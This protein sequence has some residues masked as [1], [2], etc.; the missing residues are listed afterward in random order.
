MKMK[1]QARARLLLPLLTLAFCLLAGQTRAQSVPVTLR[2]ADAPLEQVLDAIEKQ[3]SYLFVYD[4]SVDVTRKVSLDAANEPLKTVLARLAQQ[5]GVDYAVENTS[6]VLSQKPPVADAQQSVTLTGTV[7]DAQGQPVIGAAVI[8]QGTT[9]GTSTGADGNYTLRI[10]PPASSAV[11]VVN[12]LGYETL[13]IPVGSRTTLDITLRESA[14]DMDAVVVTALGIRRSEKALSY[15]AQQVN[16]DDIVAVKDVNFINSLNGKVAGLNINSSSSGIGGA[17]K[18]VMRGSKSIEQSSNAL[19]V[20]DGIPMCNF[21]SDG[22][23]EFESQGS[24]EAIADLNP[25]DIESMTVLSGAA[26]AALYGSDAA[27][28]AILITTKKGKAGQTTVTVTSNTEVLTPFVMPM[29]QTR[30]GT[31]DMLAGSTTGIYSWGS[32]LNS[33]NYRGYD[34]AD[35]YFQ[36]GVVGTETVALSTGSER[37]QTYVSAG[38]V[39][40]RG[41]I[42]NNGYDRYNFTFRNTTSFLKD[43]LKLDVGA[44]YIIQKD[45]N[46]IN[47]GVYSNPL[48]SAYLFPRGDDWSDIQMYERYNSARGISE[49]YWPSMGTDTYQMQNPYWINY[50]NLRET[51]KDRYMFNASLTYDI[52]DWLSVAGRI[53]VDNSS[54]NYTEK[55]WASTNPLRTEMSPNG[56]YG[57]TKTHDK[58]TYGDVMLNINKSFGDDWTLQANIGA[59]I[60]DMQ[61]DA[62]KVRGPIA[63]GL[64]TGY[65]KDGNPIREPNNIPN[66]F[67]VYNLSRSATVRDQIGWREQV[68]SIFFS[69][70]VGFKGAYYLT[71][72]GRN[73][74]PSQLAGPNSVNSS[75][76][77]PSFGASI[78]VSEI[79]PNM[80]K[81]LSYVK[82][83]TS[84]ASVGLAFSRFYANPTRSWNT[85]TDSWNLSSQSP[86]Y[87]LKPERTKS[88]EVGLTMRFLRHFNLDISYY[89]TRT[90]NQTFNTGIPASS[91]YSKVYKQ[92]GDVRNRGFEASLGYKNTWNRF[93]WETTFTAS[94]NRNKIMKLGQSV[95]DPNTGKERPIGDLNVGGLGNVRF[96]LREGGSLGDIYS[97]ADLRRDSN[98]D[99]YQDP[100]GNIFVDNKS[101]TKDFI[102]L[103]SVFPDANLAWRNDFRWR[104]FNFGFL[105]TARLGGVVYSRTQAVLDYYG[106]SASAADAR[107]AGGVVINGN[108]RIDA[109][110]WYQTVA[111]GDTTPQYYTYSATNVRL[112]EAS[113]GYTIPRKKLGDVCDITVSVVGRNLWMIYNKAPFDPEAVATTGNYYQGVDYFMMPSMRSIGFN[114]R[115]KF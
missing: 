41:I 10:P 5:A 66:V 42:P 61:S 58:Q 31:G 19:Y 94:A 40:S 115:V 89:N 84:Y 97:R 74:W 48:V 21:R 27:N 93:S 65:D 49:Q 1:D 2:V 100:D 96:I 50:R 3:T 114:V 64:E 92:D 113:I 110:K 62:L 55:L 54:S 13:E 38:A 34:P 79:I 59:S 63:Y 76:F 91:M 11:L 72:T 104:N 75:F 23:E 29:F 95:I 103:G 107:D 6:I 7:R 16:A 14:V 12:Y 37:S 67:N 69:A 83:R 101:Q 85:S 36:T 70:E 39:N 86:L 77:Y 109:Q 15:N 80:P 81:N 47:Q 25:E 45:R 105:L 26:A 17:S 102:K 71:V 78:V 8:I 53:R 73:D 98:G 35:D 18:V 44:S 32:R 106:V 22:G 90:V 87:D 99:I 111:N 56:L 9:L 112:Q 60:S 57:I 33:L 46:M 51:R 68:Q 4:K 88:F 30:Y 82:L 108:D 43:K 24:S 52:L 20:I 28:G